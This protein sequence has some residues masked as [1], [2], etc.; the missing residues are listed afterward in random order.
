ME[1]CGSCENL[2]PHGFPSV[3]NPKYTIV[4][5]AAMEHAISEFE[6]THKRVPE[7]PNLE[8][9]TPVAHV[10]SRDSKQVSAE[11]AES[12]FERLHNTRAAIVI[13]PIKYK[14]T[15]YPQNE[16]DYEQQLQR[17]Y[18]S[19]I[20]KVGYLKCRVCET[21]YEKCRICKNY[22]SDFNESKRCSQCASKKSAVANSMGF[23]L[24]FKIG[25]K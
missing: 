16:I 6:R 24:N 10:F 25:V 21:V 19:V 11:I 13:P 20:K 4:D 23:Q 17:T 1:C 14:I 18:P 9:T 7:V 12:E 8:Q 5:Y 3:S 15:V 22:T 2:E